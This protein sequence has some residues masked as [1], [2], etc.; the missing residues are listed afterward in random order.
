VCG[1]K[2]ATGHLRSHGIDTIGK[3][4]AYVRGPG[5]AS[6]ASPLIAGGD[7]GGSAFVPK[8]AKRR[9]KRL[10]GLVKDND[11]ALKMSSLLFRLMSAFE[12]LRVRVSK[13]LSSTLGAMIH[14]FFA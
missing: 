13:G 5:G 12:Q 9:T 7:G 1:G 3:L 8:K 11:I 6:S 4:Y 14:F 10:R 2:R